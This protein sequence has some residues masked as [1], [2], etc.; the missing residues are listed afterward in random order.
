LET[1]FQEETETD[2]FGEQAVLCG[3]VT[4]LMQAGFETLVEAGYDPEIAYFECLHEMKLIVDLIYEGGMER[5]RYSVSNTAEYGDYRTGPRIITDATK[6]EMKRVLAEIQSGEFAKDFLA[7][8][9]T[10][11]PRLKAG[12]KNTEA[13][14]LART[15]ARLRKMMPFIA[16]PK[17]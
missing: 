2:L 7:E 15:G 14:L 9:L 8:N 16:G 3:G 5:M 1:T 11:Q 4:A 6:A 13:H 10:G 12:R 17:S